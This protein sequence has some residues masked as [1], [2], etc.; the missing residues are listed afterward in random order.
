MPKGNQATSLVKPPCVIPHGLETPGLLSS[1]CVSVVVHILLS[2][3]LGWT[4]GTLNTLCNDLDFEMSQ[5]LWKSE[6]WTYFRKLG[7]AIRPREKKYISTK[8]TYE[9]YTHYV[10][11]RSARICT[12]SIPHNHPMVIWMVAH[13]KHLQHAS[14]LFWGEKYIFR[15]N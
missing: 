8:P 6:V 1:P 12:L 13:V 15:G 7:Q 10:V 11:E 2:Q 14:Y 5:I 9:C 4:Q 3:W